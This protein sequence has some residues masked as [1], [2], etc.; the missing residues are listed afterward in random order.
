MSNKVLLV[1]HQNCLDGACSAL[2]ATRALE[3]DGKTVEIALLNPIGAKFVEDVPANRQT[4]FFSQQVVKDHWQN[5]DEIIFT[6]ITPSADVLKALLQ[7]TSAKITIIDHH[8]PELDTLLAVRQDFAKAA[9]EGRL[10]FRF[11][12]GIAGGVLTYAVMEHDLSFM[13]DSED[14]LPH[15]YGILDEVG[16]PEAVRLVGDRDVFANKLEGSRAFCAALYEELFAQTDEN[17]KPVRLNGRQLIE[18]MEASGLFEVERALSGN[19]MEAT[20]PDAL[21]KIDGYIETGM[22]LIAEKEAHIKQLM[23]SAVPVRHEIEGVVHNGYMVECEPKD[24]TDVGSRL[25]RLNDAVFA[26]CHMKT[27]DGQCQISC[28][29]QDGVNVAALVKSWDASGGGHPQAAGVRVNWERGQ[30]IL[31]NLQ[32]NYAE[33]KNS[34]IHQMKPKP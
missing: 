7:Q 15:L 18:K 32:D 11:Q 2:C 8:K 6:D 22:R 28:R 14:R 26:V 24:I 34:L 10:D 29:S 12:E 17:G 4:S 20:T 19:V 3:R 21:D 23:D 1:S 27:D 16:I 5:A 13:G 25:A 30:E 31:Q 33:Y 9:G